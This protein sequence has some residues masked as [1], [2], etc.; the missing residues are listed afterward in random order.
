MLAD[1]DEAFWES[2]SLTPAGRVVKSDGRRQKW[3]PC[4]FCA[5]S[6][7]KTLTLNV[8]VAKQRWVRMLF[9][10]RI[11][12][13]TD[14]MCLWRLCLCASF[15]IQNVV[16]LQHSVVIVGRAA[17]WIILKSQLFR[18][19]FLTFVESHSQMATILSHFLLGHQ[20]HWKQA[21]LLSTFFSTDTATA[22]ES[23]WF[24]RFPP[25]RR[26]LL[27]LLLWSKF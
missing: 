4:S 11:A 1:R 27:R 23:H 6:W 9:K 17:T 7:R 26:I 24:C 21:L 25:P 5:S 8:S 22:C 3:L 15:S 18:S 14:L 16:L 12:F 19:R 13:V 10:T 2:L 20:L